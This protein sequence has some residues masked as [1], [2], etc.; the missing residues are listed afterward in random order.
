MPANKS[1][2]WCILGHIMTSNAFVASSTGKTGTR[3]IIRDILQHR[4][5]SPRGLDE[6]HREHLH[7]SPQSL[8]QT[9]GVFWDT[10]EPQL[11]LLLA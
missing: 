5:G 1:D 11:R 2:A 9:L 7:P 6:S 3:H 4:V 8:S 10:T